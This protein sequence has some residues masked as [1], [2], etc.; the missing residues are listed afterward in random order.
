MEG[1][2]K[3][4]DLV[5]ERI[6]AEIQRIMREGIDTQRFEID[7]RVRYG[8]KI[9]SINDVKACADAMLYYHFDCDDITLFEDVEIIASLTAQ[10]CR[11][12]LAELFDINKSSISIVMDKI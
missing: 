4:P 2:S 1:E 3:D 6:T 8:E 12:A 7:K 5:Y 11:E 9:S 10:E